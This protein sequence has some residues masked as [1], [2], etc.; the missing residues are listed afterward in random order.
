MGTIKSLTFFLLWLC[1][2]WSCRAG[3]A[4]SLRGEGD[5]VLIKLTAFN[6]CSIW[7]INDACRDHA[8][9]CLV[10]FF[11][12]EG[13]PVLVLEEGWGEIVMTL[14][15][16]FFNIL[17]LLLFL[18]LLIK[19]LWKWVGHSGLALGWSHGV[20]WGES[21]CTGSFS[22]WPKAWQ[23]TGMRWSLFCEAFS[24]WRLASVCAYIFWC[25]KW[26]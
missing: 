11:L 17:D 24:W 22:R 7:G 10:L 6:P 8:D 20:R 2:P 26:D 21:V 5:W 3:D 13:G 9:W 23:I 12:W 19:L 1:Y 16:V 18:D 4:V 25:W 14:F 15:F